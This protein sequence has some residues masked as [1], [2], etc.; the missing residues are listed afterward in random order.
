[1]ASFLLVYTNTLVYSTRKIIKAIKSLM[2]H[3]PGVTV[4]KLRSERQMIWPDELE[5]LFMAS[6]FSL[7]YH[8]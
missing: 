8:L 4:L 1:L 6:L 7:V 3:A 2:T 5:H